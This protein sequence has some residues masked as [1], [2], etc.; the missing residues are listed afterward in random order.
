MRPPNISA[1]HVTIN[2][3]KTTHNYYLKIYF[4][5]YI[6]IDYEFFY[7][8]VYNLALHVHIEGSDLKV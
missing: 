2:F 3:N 7:L 5:L 6:M 8:Y 1:F 4:F